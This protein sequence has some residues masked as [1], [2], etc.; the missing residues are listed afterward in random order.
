MYSAVCKTVCILWLAVAVGIAAHVAEE[1]SPAARAGLPGG[2]EDGEQQSPLG[3]LLLQ[4]K[5][6]L[7]KGKK[8][9]NGRSRYGLRGQNQGVA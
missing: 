1:E 8:K 7:W 5:H 2:R 3:V 9:Q 4:Q 6:A